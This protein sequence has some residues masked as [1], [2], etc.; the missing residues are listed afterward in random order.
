MERIIKLVMICLGELYIYEVYFQDFEGW[1][2]QDTRTAI[3]LLDKNC[4]DTMK[5][6]LL[7][8]YLIFL[9]FCP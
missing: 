6:I 7:S 8:F 5:K 2:H 9:V 4:L 3:Y 1:K